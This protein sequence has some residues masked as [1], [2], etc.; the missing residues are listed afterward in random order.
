MKSPPVP[1][2]V[3][4]QQYLQC[5]LYHS[6]GAY[7]VA[8]DRLATLEKQIRDTHNQASGVPTERSA[9]EQDKLLR[10]TRLS[11]EYNELLAQRR[12][13][14]PRS[15]NDSPPGMS[16]HPIPDELPLTLQERFRADDDAPGVKDARRNPW[17]NPLAWAWVLNFYDAAEAALTV[18]LAF[19]QKD[20]RKYESLDRNNKR[21]AKLVRP[22]ADSVAW[23]RDGWDTVPEIDLE[24]MSLRKDRFAERAAF[25][26]QKLPGVPRSVPPRSDD[27]TEFLH[28]IATD[29]LSSG[30]DSVPYF[31]ISAAAE[32]HLSMH[33]VEGWQSMSLGARAE[34]AASE[35]P[36][37]PEEWLSRELDRCI[38]LDTFV[39]CTSRCAPWMFAANDAEC[40]Q[41]FENVRN[42]WTYAVPP[43]CMWISAQVSLLALHRR[44]YSYALKGEPTLAY[45]DYHKLQREIRNARR[46][47]DSAPVHITGAVEFL[48]A[49]NARANQNIGELYRAEHAHRPALK[50]YQTALESMETVREHAEMSEV[51]TNSRWYVEL[52]MSQ[53][54]AS[55][56]M[57]KHKESLRWHLLAWQAFLKLLAGET[58]TEASTEKIDEALEWLEGIRFEPEVRKSEVLE[59]LAPVVEQ[60]KRV[61]VSEKLGTLAAEILLRL[62]HVLFVLNLEPEPALDGNRQKLPAGMRIVENLSFECLKTAAECDPYSTLAGADLLKSYFRSLNRLRLEKKSMSSKVLEN[63]KKN[64][65]LPEMERVEE[66]WPRG[67]EDY[68]RITRVAEYLMLLALDINDVPAPGGKSTLAQV[69][70]KLAQR[71]L[72]D[73]FMHTD[74]INVRKEQTHHYLMRERQ[75]SGLPTKPDQAAIEFICMRRYSSATPLLPRPSAFRAHGGGYF[76]RLH[77]ERDEPAPRQPNTTGSKRRTSALPPPPPPPFGIVVDPGPD[78]IENLYRTGFS[79][80][81]IDMIVVTHDHVD[82]LNSLE[83][84]L[85]LMHYRSDLLHHQTAGEPAN[86]AGNDKASDCKEAQ[87]REERPLIVYGNAS[88]C[89]RYDKVEILNPIQKSEQGRKQKQRRFR[90]LGELREGAPQPEGFPPD[91]Q[92][93][94]MS[95]AAMDE[96]GHMDLSGKPSYGI[97]LRHLGGNAKRRKRDRISLAITSDTP[98]PPSKQDTEYERWRRIWSPALRADALVAHMSTVPLSELRQLARLDARVVVRSGD[99]KKLGKQIGA[100]AKKTKDSN[101]ELRSIS[102]ELEG[103]IEKDPSHPDLLRESKAVK[104]LRRKTTSLRDLLKDLEVNLVK[105]SKASSPKGMQSAIRQ[106]EEA[107][108]KVSGQ[109]LDLVMPLKQIAHRQV[110]RDCLLG[111]VD[112]AQTLALEAQRLP[113][114]AVRLE[115]I[116]SRL[117]AVGDLRGRIEFAMWLRSRSP[118]PTADMV[119]LVP[120]DLGDS[121]KH[122]LPP[123]EHPYLRGTLRWARAYQKERKRY[124]RRSD[125]ALGLFVLGELSEE[126]GT[127]RGKIAGRINETLF[128]HPPR[129]NRKKGV[130]ALTSDVGLHLVVVAGRIEAK[131]HDKQGKKAQ[132]ARI[133]AKSRHHPAALAAKDI[134]NPTG[135]VA[136]G[137]CVK[138]LCTTCDLDTDRTSMERYHSPNDVYEVCVKGENEGVFYNCAHHNPGQQPKPLFLEQLER[139][140]VFG[141]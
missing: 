119:G 59:H 110:V 35:R 73:F 109:A 12:H 118:G 64:L 121:T 45:N 86:R 114:D 47:V 63:F 37:K 5:E 17:A 29:N 27:A 30:L 55:Y 75:G 32:A 26:L 68:E 20:K 127:V 60:L 15:G 33:A 24:R 93:I 132:K 7:G 141:R 42:G 14:A 137:A 6:I 106:A 4:L 69:N 50:H 105:L 123:R 99:V 70:Q 102:L 54:K 16:R 139:F 84:L 77:S 74:S 117:E 78:F 122:W 19:R 18:E 31:V 13:W 53:G 128:G 44:A 89:Q 65:K 129:S 138:I 52:Q 92:I 120:S 140:D 125:K 111:L 95:S 94:S 100:L 130:Y 115:E 131:Q 88:V 71:L 97:C 79:L 8:R 91:F 107:A 49:L 83:P 61:R 136:A 116:R 104:K 2:Q 22:F 87:A 112:D 90:D 36:W 46:R 85:S 76:V 43:R 67:G 25:A 1:P 9:L 72:L 135:R 3:L 108:T 113:R 126:L 58:H 21:A 124:A 62:G 39:F 57:G 82:H 38:V 10:V 98:A 134:H 41:L 103:L 11:R 34:R 28:R 66:Q 40:K 96:L 81:D 101:L 51:L 23:P 48:T 56:E 133:P 80:S